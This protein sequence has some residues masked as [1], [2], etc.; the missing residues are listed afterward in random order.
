MDLAIIKYEIT[1]FSDKLPV[2]Q[3]LFHSS[4]QCSTSRSCCFDGAQQIAL[5]NAPL[6]V[7]CEG[8]CHAQIPSLHRFSTAVSWRRNWCL[9]PETAGSRTHFWPLKRV[10][11]G[12]AIAFRNIVRCWQTFN[13]SH[14]LSTL[15]IIVFKCLYIVR[16]KRRATCASP[17]LHSANNCALI[18]FRGYLDSVQISFLCPLTINA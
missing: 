4:D 17:S 18:C 15:F 12:W 1:C 9:L 16:G 5:P 3:G 7:Q 11:A 10:A 13:W 8:W 2:L 6:Q 14:V